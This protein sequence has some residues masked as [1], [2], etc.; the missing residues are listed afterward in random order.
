M[1]YKIN[2]VLITCDLSFINY[3]KYLSKNINYKYSP[4]L[5]LINLK[6]NLSNFNGWICS[7]TPK[8][9]I[10][11][12][13]LK[14]SKDLKC[15]VTPS[16]GTNHIDLEECKKRGISVISL[17]GTKFVNK[18]YASSEFTFMLALIM[19]KKLLLGMNEVKNYNWRKNEKNFRGFEIYGKKIAIIGMGRIG[20]NL[21]RYFRSFGAKIN[22]YDIKKI[23]IPKYINFHK[24][25][26]D[27]IK[28]AKIVFICVKLNKNS[29]KLI[30]K[31]IFNLMNNE[32]ILIN[33]SRG[34]VI[35][36]KE[37][38]HSLKYNKIES[39]AID[40]L[41]EEHMLSKKKNKLIEYS[42]RHSNLL[43]T[44]H[45]AG[46]SYDS[47]TKAAKFAIKEMNNFFK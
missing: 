24:N 38:I 43:I 32:T 47:E 3:K 21:S 17:S 16:T 13:L 37:L 2:K 31:K 33:T 42:K 46:V 22:A 45:M 25:I 44:P 7:P 1:T 40:V 11:K 26:E 23:K 5:S 27:A 20:K 36:E 4:N 12:S 41:S 15:I 28:D 18:I 34:E 10:D 30:N 39:A 8:Y 35:D 14:L 9:R 29:Y 6:H 19:M